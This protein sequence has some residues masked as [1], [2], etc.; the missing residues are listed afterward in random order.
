MVKITELAV[1]IRSKNA[2]PL[3]LTLDIVFR[4]RRAFEKARRSGVL[5]ENLVAKLYHIP[6]EKVL[7]AVWFTP[8][9]AFKATIARTVMAGDPTD[10]DI[11]G[12][13][14]HVPLLS[15]DIP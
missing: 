12:S 14:Q 3:E 7:S 11:Y 1:V 8:G 10:T 9:N 15:I 13:Q 5:S 4:D 6:K 2:K